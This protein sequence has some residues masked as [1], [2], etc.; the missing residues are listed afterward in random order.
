MPDQEIERRYVPAGVEPIGLEERSAASPTIKGIS[1]P[2][3][4]KS[5][6]LGNF[7][8]V[9][10]PTAFD[11]VVGRHKNDPRGGM[12]VVA[13]FNHEGQPIGRTTN[14]TLKLSIIERGLA[15]SISPPDT[16]LGRD[17]ITLVRRGDLYGASFA[18]SVAPGGESWTQEADGSAVRT[19]SEVGALYDVSVVTRPAYSQAS[20][21]LRSLDAWRQQNLNSHELE[22]L[23]ERVADEAADKRRRW[24]YALTAAS[25]RLISARLKS[26]APRIK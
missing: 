10:A 11:K 21:A 17:I 13:L 5:E 16:T 25:A 23:A 7:R 3:N 12:D 18:F 2:F 14:D 19:V 8:E 9:F 15:Y 24:S 22:Q 6:D 4:S 26:N 20:A 1:P